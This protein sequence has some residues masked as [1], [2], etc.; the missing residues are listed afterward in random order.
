MLELGPDSATSNG[1]GELPEHGVRTGDIVVVSEQPSGSAKKREVKELEAK[2]SKGVVTRTGKG[3]VWVALDGEDGEEGVVGMKR[4]W[5]VKLANDV[6]YKRFVLLCA[7]DL[8]LVGVADTGF[9]MNQTMGKLQKMK[10]DEYSSFLRVLFGLESP[11][12]PKNLEDE[13]TKIDWIDPSLNDSQ[14]HA[15]KFA[16]AS[17]EVCG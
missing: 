6:T 1:E 7:S 15:I 5:V 11:L 9:R 13:E 16:L 8:L 10:E 17:R 4:V 2:G 3:A 12:I 14:K